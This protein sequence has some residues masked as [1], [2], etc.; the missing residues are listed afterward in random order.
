MKLYTNIF[1]VV[2]G[3]AFVLVLAISSYHQPNLAVASS[4]LYD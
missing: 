2:I 1:K 4:S 3:L